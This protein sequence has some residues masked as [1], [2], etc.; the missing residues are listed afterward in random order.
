MAKVEG[1]EFTDDDSCMRRSKVD[2]FEDVVAVRT[3]GHGCF[4][5][6]DWYEK[7]CE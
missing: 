6:V 7:E 5:R 1:Y 3:V 4:H 2:N